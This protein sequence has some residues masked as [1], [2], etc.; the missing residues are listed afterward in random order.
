MEGS[1]TTQFES[2]IYLII[3]F[4]LDGC[5]SVHCYLLEN[6]VTYFLFE[7]EL[8]KMNFK[9]GSHRSQFKPWCK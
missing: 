9:A 6:S 7:I 5:S 8:Q 3:F 2:Y 4:I 1:K